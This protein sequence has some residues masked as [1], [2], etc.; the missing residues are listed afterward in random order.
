[1]RITEELRHQARELSRTLRRRHDGLLRQR[2]AIDAE[3]AQ[4]A[5]QLEAVEAAFELSGHAEAP[6]S[7][8]DGSCA[9]ADTST[10]VEPCKPAESRT[11]RTEL[12]EGLL[13]KP[14]DELVLELFLER[15]QARTIEIVRELENAG[16]SGDRKLV[17]NHVQKLHEHGMLR[18][19][20]RGVYQPAH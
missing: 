1:M 4:I 12:A 3:L 16:W 18:R 5:A 9:A 15:E 11:D 7:P 19:V 13:D 14:L 2:R 6:S 17:Y 20:S 10:P 8:L